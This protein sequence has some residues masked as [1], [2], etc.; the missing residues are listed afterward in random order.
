MSVCSNNVREQADATV[1]WD[2]KIRFLIVL[3]SFFSK[4]DIFQLFSEKLLTKS[5]PRVM[6]YYARGGMPWIFSLKEDC[7]TFVFL[8]R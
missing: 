5:I 3:K 7:L 4:N 2:L 8:P 1:G 6:M